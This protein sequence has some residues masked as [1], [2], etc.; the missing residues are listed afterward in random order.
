VPQFATGRGAGI[1]S[2][3]PDDSPSA[4]GWFQVPAAL[5]PK[6]ADIQLLLAAR[7]HIGTQNLEPRMSR[8]VWRR[9]ADGLHLINIAKTWEKLVLA[10]RIIVTIE[11]PAD[12]VVLSTPQVGQRA[13]LKF[14]KFTGAQAL[15]GRFTPGTFT[16][17][18][19][20]HF[21]EPRLLIISDPRDDSQAL[22]EASYVNIPTIAFATTDNFVR[23]ADVVIPCNNRSTESLGL[24]FW[25]LAREVL[26]LR[27][28]LSRS[29]PWD[30]MVDL[31]FWRSVD[32]QA[33]LAAADAAAAAAS[34]QN[35][36]GQQA[37]QTSFDAIES[38]QS[39]FDHHHAPH[40]QQ[41]ADAAWAEA[42]G[43]PAEPWNQPG[44]E[45]E[46]SGWADSIPAPL[47]VANWGTQTQF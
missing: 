36:A 28:Q 20:A 6:E 27:G 38:A 11:N 39:S 34:Q 32:E 45:G 14:A 42:G 1:E 25:L 23:N 17:Q 13:V 44:A 33:K 8:Y 41:G 40:H 24:M 26:R 37:L 19:Q 46:S 43:Q 10:A 35:Q 16:N 2:A 3:H 18:I 29:Q 47:P 9:R 15:A 7:A 30:V 12:V 4:P 21:L 31:F 5:H 22:N